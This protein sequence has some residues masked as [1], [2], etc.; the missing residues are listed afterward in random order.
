MKLPEG[1]SSKDFNAAMDEF[2]GI[3]GAPWVFTSDEDVG[4]Y[5]DAYS[6][7]WDE[8]EELVPSAAVAP[9][10]VE[11]V[12]AIVR[13]AGKYKIPLFAISTGKNLGYGGS[14][15]NLTG[16]VIVDLKRM[17][18][19]IE[20][21]D[22]RNFCIVEPGVSLLRSV[23]VHPGSQA[24]GDDGHPRPGLGQS[25]GQR[26]GPRR[27]LTPGTPTATTTAPTAAWRWCCR[28]VS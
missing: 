12:Q 19:V 4:L 20:V 21:N 16:S 28:T 1:V 8:P 22:K 27:R 24:Q 14:A 6:P 11:E 7:W 9:A 3:V 10:T 5:R 17:D 15:P 2:R 25:A 23:Q 26:A 13:V 18:K